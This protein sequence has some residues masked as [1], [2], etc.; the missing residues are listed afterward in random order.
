MGSR[1]WRPP[2]CANNPSARRGAFPNSTLS[3]EE[4]QKRFCHSFVPE[5]SIAASTAVPP[6]LSPLVAIAIRNSPGPVT[7]TLTTYSWIQLSL[8]DLSVRVYTHNL[9]STSESACSL[10]MSPSLAP[11]Y[12]SPVLLAA[13]GIRAA[14]GHNKH[15]L[16]AWY[17]YS[18]QRRCRR[19]RAPR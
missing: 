9:V 4:N 1:K 19:C 15:S 2:A 13:N 6:S 10:I 5:E 8:T 14:S 17:C 7:W 16:T 12:S 18:S 11:K 3:A